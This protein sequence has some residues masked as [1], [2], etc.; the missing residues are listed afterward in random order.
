MAIKKTVTCDFCGEE[1]GRWFELSARPTA[2]ESWQ[3]I[4]DMIPGNGSFIWQKQICN[5]CFTKIF[6]VERKKGKWIRNNNDTYSCS[7][8][9][10]W[11]PEEQ[12]YYAQ[13]CLY[14]GADMRGLTIGK[15]D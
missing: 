10:S 2:K 11:I 7:L 3:N 6:L 14:C 4:A 8:C 1:C 15:V 13:F 9:Q 12:Y 5:D